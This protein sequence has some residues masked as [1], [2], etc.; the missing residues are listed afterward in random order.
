MKNTLIKLNHVSKHYEEGSD[1]R[2]ILTDINAEIKTTEVV[3]FIGK[4]GIGKSTLLNLISGIDVC[5]S[6]DITIDGVF[7]NKLSDTKRTLFRRKNIGFVFQ[8]FNLVST[9][10]IEE[11]IALP[12]KLNKFDPETTNQTV[13]RLLE[14]VGLLDRKKSFPDKLSGGEQQRIAV[15]RALSH[16]PKLIIADEPTG[17][18]DTNNSSMLM[19]LLVSLAKEYGTTIIIATHS[20]EVLKYSDRIMSIESGILIEK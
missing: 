16:N 19:G 10:T 8:F 7:I 15:A 11:N 17:N 13:D 18:L 1:N 20:D 3:S 12:L 5:D 6:G 14:H 9:L 2:E 4:S